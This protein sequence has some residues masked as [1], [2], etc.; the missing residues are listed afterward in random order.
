[1]S[2]GFLQGVKLKAD[3]L[4]EALV[5]AGRLDVRVELTGEREVVLEAIEAKQVETASA[6]QKIRDALSA[7]QRDVDRWLEYMKGLTGD[8]HAAEMKVYSAEA[9]SA[10]SYLLA[11]DEGE[12]AYSQL[13]RNLEQLEAKYVSMCGPKA[14]PPSGSKV[15]TPG[16][17]VK[18][19]ATR[20]RPA[21]YGHSPGGGGRRT[22]F[23]SPYGEDSEDKREGF[24]S[25]GEAYHGGHGHSGVRRGGMS[26]RESVG[27][28]Y[29]PRVK[30]PKIRLP[31]FSGDITEFKSFW[32]TF[33]ATIDSQPFSKV[34]KLAYLKGLLKGGAEQAVSGYPVTEESYDVIV[35]VL[36]ER[37]GNEE[38]I[39]HMLYNELDDMPRSG[40]GI[41]E[42]RQVYEKLEKVIRMLEALGENVDQTH[43]GIVYASCMPSWVV[44]KIHEKKGCSNDWSVCQLRLVVGDAIRFKELVAFMEE[45]RTRRVIAGRAPV[46][47]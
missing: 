18:Q 42:T 33:A 16:R 2:A 22:D 24:E 38:L 17:V 44:S 1:M 14:V 32:D 27:D 15:F 30:L 7:I 6:I 36:H 9:T 29:R 13:K 11:V 4:K 8:V 47:R 10:S 25:G 31:E 37:Y 21:S 41:K 28:E 19:T 3:R 43:I 12:A 26:P 34:E 46:E 40:S 23:H 5:E 39:V 20:G 45:T 35:E